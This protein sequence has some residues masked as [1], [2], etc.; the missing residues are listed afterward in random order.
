MIKGF[1]RFSQRWSLQRKSEGQQ[2]VRQ[3]SHRRYP[4]LRF[5]ILRGNEGFLSYTRAATRRDYYIFNFT[6]RYPRKEK[7]L[8]HTSI[9]DHWVPS[10]SIMNYEL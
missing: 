7:E 10:F 1:S 3:K 5:S 6:G 4:A 2:G 8:C 9:T